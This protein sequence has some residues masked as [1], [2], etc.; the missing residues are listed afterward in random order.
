MKNKMKRKQMMAINWS[1]QQQQ[2]ITSI[3]TNELVNAGAGSGKTAVL[4]EHV[5]YLL[6]NGY[7]LNEIL[8]MTFTNLAANEM[9]QRIKKKIDEK[10]NLRKKFSH[11][12]DSSHIET[13][14]AFALFLVRKYHYLF[15]IEKNVNII[16]SSIL[17][18]QKNKILNCIFDKK[19]EANDLNF[20]NLIKKYCV[21]SDDNL[22]NL[23]LAIHELS[24]KKV[25]K[26]EY[27][28]NYIQKHYS[29]NFIDELILIR[30]KELQKSIIYLKNAANTLQDDRDVESLNV[31]FDNLLQCQDY[32]DL[33]G[34]LFLV[35][36]PNKPRTLKNSNFDDGKKRES[37][38]KEYKKLLKSIGFKEEIKSN[39]F[40]QKEDVQTLIGIAIELDNELDEFKRKHN[41]YDFSDIALMALKI[42]ENQNILKELKCIFK[43]IMVDEYQDTSDIQESLI[44]KLANNNVFMVGD[45]KQSIYRF[46]NANCN[47]F[48]EK[49]NR[50]SINNGGHKIDMTVNYRSREELIDDFNYV[51]SNLM[52]PEYNLIDY[53]DGHITEFGEQKYNQFKNI[54]QKYGLSF[55]RY[56]FD[57]NIGYA[58]QEAKIIA[59]D[60]IHKINEKFEIFDRDINKLRSACFSDF[61]III[62]RG[63][64]FDYYRRVFS[65]FNIPLFVLDDE[66]TNKKDLFMIARSLIIVYH[67]FINQN[68]D[69]KFKHA[70]ISLARSF[71]CEYD[72]QKIYQIILKN[73]YC[74]DDIILK[75][76]KVCKDYQ[77]HSLKTILIALFD[78]FDFVKKI[79]KVGD[80]NSYIYDY[81]IS[82]NL[83]DTLD[84]LHYTLD[85]CVEYLDDLK[86]NKS[87]IKNP[88]VNESENAVTL[89]NIHKSKGLEYSICYYAGIHKAF[90]KDDLK[91]KFGVSSKYGIYLP[92]VGSNNLE[93]IVK[94]LHISLEEKEDF[95]E[96]LR[97]LYVAI[98]RAKECAI[99]LTRSNLSN[100][101]I[102]LTKAKSFEQML[103]SINFND[104]YYCDVSIDEVALKEKDV[105]DN[106][107]FQLKQS[108]KFDFI[109][110]EKKKASK[111]LSFSVDESII[112]LGN[113]LH[114]ILEHCNFESKDLS[115]ITNSYWKQKIANII[116]LPIFNNVKN[117]QIR[118]EFPFFDNDNQVYGII[119]CLL[120]KDDEID[121]IDFKLKNIDDI[122]YLKQ[123]QTYYNYISTIANGRK[124]KTYLISIIDAIVKEVNCDE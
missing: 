112:E 56:I 80:Y 52:K 111:T 60:I 57:K 104:K 93:N 63:S 4:S 29:E 19:Y 41:V 83:M 43:Y 65:E 24:E 90:N 48:Q 121:I 99:I 31:F 16:D 72:D 28:T 6:E 94:C 64:D 54:K 124:I 106:I 25:D 86:T 71:L 47:I 113:Q 78:A 45:V 53:L 3:N 49:Y 73:N 69:S 27:L 123:L 2:A 105:E 36:F 74:D 101:P 75:I 10:P 87:D 20:I 85:D 30:F 14:D 44:L 46:R 7:Q 89:L 15:D 81:N 115:F 119:D 42:V 12:V 77:H 5:I 91:G 102:N 17:N 58:T 8:I 9:K 120:I 59:S 70:F 37:I 122:A 1:K 88:P 66:I 109:K 62:D 118:H 33:Y 51:F 98:T 55:Y 92:I 11:L 21:K 76:N 40:N 96:K 32:D 35:S 100:Q 67:S 23:V 103:F 117:E 110:I 22:K 34:Q 68:F 84:K 50:Y 108:P 107:D 26:K 61:A 95:Q 97:L 39:H 38:K 116:N 18:I 13:F 82:I 79:Q 114:S